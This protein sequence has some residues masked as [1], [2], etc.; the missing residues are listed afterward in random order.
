MAVILT[1][2]QMPIQCCQCEFSYRLNNASTACLRNPAEKP[3]E[4]GDERPKYC[5]LKEVK[6]DE[7]FEKVIHGLECCSFDPDVFPSCDR[8]PYSFCGEKCED[9]QTGIRC[10]D[11]LKA[12]I[13]KL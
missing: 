13:S 6:E 2:M 11:E 9:N 1:D 10:C 5:P 8:C 7:N 12:D 4:D 3:V